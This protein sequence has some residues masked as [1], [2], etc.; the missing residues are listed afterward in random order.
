LIVFDDLF[1]GWLCQ[2]WQMTSVPYPASCSR[3]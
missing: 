1:V 2:V 3:W